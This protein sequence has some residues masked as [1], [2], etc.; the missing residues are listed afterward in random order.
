MAKD[1]QSAGDEKPVTAF[2]LKN[3]STSLKGVEAYLTHRGWKLKTSEKLR[4]ALLNL[5][6]GKPDFF[7]FPSDFPNKKIK[8]LPPLIKQAFPTTKLVA[9]C[10]ASSPAALAKLKDAGV[11]FTLYPPVSGTT[12]ER[13]VLRVL[14]SADEKKADPDRNFGTKE[15]TD[16]SS[17]S[18]MLFFRSD[19]KDSGQMQGSIDQAKDALS[20]ILMVAGGN[21]DTDG[22][23]ITQPD[24]ES[25]PLRGDF[26]VEKGQDTNPLMYLKKDKHGKMINPG[27]AEEDDS[28]LGA[29]MR[30]LMLEDS[31]DPSSGA[32]RDDGNDTARGKLGKVQTSE[33]VEY[34]SGLSVFDEN[35]TVIVKGTREALRETVKVSGDETNIEKIREISNATCIVVESTRFNGYLIAASAKKDGVDNFFFDE[36]KQKLFE[37][38][39]AYGEE[40]KADSASMSIK[41]QE[42]DFEPWALQQADF[43]K[44]AAHNGNEIAMAFFPTNNTQTE[45]GESSAEHMMA[46]KMDD[47]AEDANVEFDLYIF[48]PENKKYLLYTPQGRTLFKKQKDRLVEKGMTQMHLRK[49][50]TAQVRKYRAQNFLNDKIKSFRNKNSSNEVA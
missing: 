42:V 3:K 35:E 44:K 4:D 18:E 21:D 7:F 5:I 15:S 2:I 23:H 13:L 31:A 36:V 30:K 34:L 20:K 9:Y 48:M 1:D 33:A 27:N 37:F 17:E 45:L 24:Q 29:L 47:L 50:S 6:Q 12:I 49:D 8:A 28:D 14:R 38:L 10:E 41:L 43:L 11:E 25:N 26:A 39:K 40:F 32:T 22:P 19:K 46:M 16:K